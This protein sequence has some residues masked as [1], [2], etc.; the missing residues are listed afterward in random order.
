MTRRYAHTQRSPIAL[1]ILLGAGFLLAGAWLTRE[2]SPVVATALAII[3]ATVVVLSFCFG[4]LTV[5]VTD[6]E[7]RLRYGPLPL[8]RRTFPLASI[9]T[10]QRGRSALIDGWGIHY[11]PGRGW[12]YNLWGTECVVL[13]VNGRLVRVGSDD[14]DALAAHL[15][16]RVNAAVAH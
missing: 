8:F 16:S 3:G 10:V 6:D 7:L 4:S 12:T 9:E 11:V 13:N 14:A 2:T 1:V 5:M 15:Q